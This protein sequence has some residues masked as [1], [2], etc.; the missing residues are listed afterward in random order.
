MILNISLL[1]GEGCCSE[2]V[3]KVW[4]E[5]NDKYICLIKRDAFIGGCLSCCIWMYYVYLIHNLVSLCN[6][7]YIS[8]ILQC[9]AKVYSKSI[10]VTPQWSSQYGVQANCHTILYIIYFIMLYY[11]YKYSK[12]LTKKNKKQKQRTILT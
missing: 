11:K 7:S 10:Q 1:W 4:V 8:S 12:V 5:K 6:R 3:D 2:A 9:I